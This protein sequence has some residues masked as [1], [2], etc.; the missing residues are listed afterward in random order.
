MLQHLLRITE[1]ALSIIRKCRDRD[2]KLK[3]QAMAQA[4]VAANQAAALAEANGVEQR[5]PVTANAAM[6]QAQKTY[7]ENTKM[8][9]LDVNAHIQVSVL[10]GDS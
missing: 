5:P 8:I 6:T 10:L 4:Q 1:S 7:D 3:N 9:H 2:L